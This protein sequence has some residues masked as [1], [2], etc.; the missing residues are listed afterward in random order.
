M[1][2][3]IK[4]FFLLSAVFIGF[5]VVAWFYSKSLNKDLNEQWAEKF[6]KQQ[7][8]FDKYRT[9]LPILREVSLVRNMAKN[10]ALLDMAQNDESKTSKISGLKVLESYRLKF[11]DRNY[12][13]AFKKSKNYYFNN[14]ENEYP[15][16]EPSY[17]LSRESKDDQWFFEVLDLKDEYQIN[18]NIDTVLRTTKVWINYLLKDKNSSTIGVVGAGLDLSGFLKESVD[19]KQDGIRNIFINKNMAI[20]LDKNMNFIDYASI[21]KNIDEQNNMNLFLKSKKDIRLLSVFMKELKNQSSAD[22]MKIG[23]VDFDD[24]NQLMSV[25]YIKEL[26]WFSVTFISQKELILIDNTN[27]FIILVVF[28]FILLL[29]INRLYNKLVIEPITS[30]EKTMNKAHHGTYDIQMHIHG[31]GEIANLSRN[32]KELLHKINT[33]NR[34]LEEKIQERTISLKSSEEKLKHLAFYDS[35][36]A[37]PN[38]RLFDDRLN[39]SI[40]LS[41]RKKFHLAV[42][43]LDLDNFK[44]VNDM[45]GHTVGDHLLVEVAKRLENT[46]RKVDTVARFGGDEFIIL[47]NELSQEKEKA[48]Q[49]IENIVN[50][51]HANL[52]STFKLNIGTKDER[53]FIDYRCGA[54]IG[55]KM[56]MGNEITKDEIIVQ[57]DIAMYEAK[58]LGKNQIF[59]V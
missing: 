47:L 33:N 48:I 54:S 11:Q 46:V 35:L 23:W 27:L 25:V 26:D 57:A 55:T 10:K 53:I 15:G 24:E 6:I 14:L 40:E 45:Y 13:A 59:Y 5:S 20:Q 19:I 4:L 42:V 22:L 37:L 21:S 39:Q 31:S 43:F 17:K 12:F 49:D 7:M 52:T 29:T 16:I 50:K 41:E 28:S 56:F 44:P 58:K 34:Y 38:R 18:V 51:I 30:L 3:K 2:I 1:N 9:L 36:T 32:F 8:I